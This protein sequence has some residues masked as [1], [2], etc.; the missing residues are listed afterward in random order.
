[1]MKKQ[2]NMRK[3]SNINYVW[4][5]NIKNNVKNIDVRV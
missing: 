1:M 5:N 4:Y 3:I 2:K